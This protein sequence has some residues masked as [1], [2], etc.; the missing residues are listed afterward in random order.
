MKKAFFF[1]LIFVI[2]FII[3]CEK[4][5][6]ADY[7]LI[8]RSC[9]F[10][11]IISSDKKISSLVDEHYV[12]DFMNYLNSSAAIASGESEKIYI[13]PIVQNEHS[14]KLIVRQKLTSDPTV[15]FYIKATVDSENRLIIYEKL[16]YSD[17]EGDDGSLC[18]A[19]FLIEIKEINIDL[20]TINKI[21]LCLDGLCFCETDSE[22]VD[23]IC[24]SLME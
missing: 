2:F 6:F 9:N 23:Y 24:N 20:T 1:I 14:M 18:W 7:A 12:Y 17:S 13:F 4:D 10:H 21:Q 15:D 5:D 3:S 22:N 19:T 16:N 11:D 8:D